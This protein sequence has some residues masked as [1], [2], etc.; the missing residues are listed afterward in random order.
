MTKGMPTNER[1][2]MMRLVSKDTQKGVSTVRYW[3]SH[4]ND[5]SGNLGHWSKPMEVRS[6]KDYKDIER[7]FQKQNDNRMQPEYEIRYS[8]QRGNYVKGETKETVGEMLA[9]PQRDYIYIENVKSMLD[10]IRDD[11]LRDIRSNKSG[12]SRGMNEQQQFEYFNSLKQRIID[13]LNSMSHEELKNWSHANKQLMNLSFDYSPTTGFQ[14]KTGLARAVEIASRLGVAN[15]YD[16]LVAEDKV[17]AIQSITQGRAK[18]QKRISELEE[19]E[20]QK[21]LMEGS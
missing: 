9:Q 17:K 5:K 18:F 15:V 13:K 6:A 10:G 20:A 16:D 7:Y 4:S 14:E 12:V 8:D 2:P 19:M 1:R 11:F 3:V 21:D